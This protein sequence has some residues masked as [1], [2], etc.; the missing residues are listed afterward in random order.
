MSKMNLNQLKTT[1]VEASEGN[2]IMFRTI[3]F[4]QDRTPSSLTKES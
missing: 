2:R 4:T 3:P 1:K